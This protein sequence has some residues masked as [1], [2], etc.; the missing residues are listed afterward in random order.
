MGHRLWLTLGDQDF[1][2]AG[3][4]NRGTPDLWRQ[5][6]AAVVSGFMATGKDR[7][8]IIHERPSNLGV[9]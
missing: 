2:D 8:H 6:V 1:H 4:K 7:D 9:M 3:W 5:A